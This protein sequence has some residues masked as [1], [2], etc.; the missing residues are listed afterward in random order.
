[1]PENYP[2]QAPQVF[3]VTQIHHMNVGPRNQVMRKG[4]HIANWWQPTMTVRS[5][6]LDVISE[7]GKFYPDE[8]MMI[9]GVGNA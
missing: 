6:I 2:A 4:D 5:L 9:P 8:A 1:M 7:L 3:F